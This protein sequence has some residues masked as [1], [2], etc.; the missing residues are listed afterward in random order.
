[1]LKVLSENNP[2]LGWWKHETVH[3]HQDLRLGDGGRDQ[4]GKVDGAGCGG[5]GEEVGYGGEPD[6]V[7]GER[8]ELKP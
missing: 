2:T 4:E 8:K 1:M 7:L 3:T 6:L 5:R